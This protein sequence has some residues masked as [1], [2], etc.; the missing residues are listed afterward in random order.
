MD[1]HAAT[2]LRRGHEDWMT[3]A[4]LLIDTCLVKYFIVH[5]R[6]ITCRVTREKML[7]DV[8]TAVW[9]CRGQTSLLWKEKWPRPR[10]SRKH[11]RV[12]FHLLEN[13]T[14]L[15]RANKCLKRITKFCLQKKKYNYTKDDS[16]ML[17]TQRDSVSNYYRDRFF[18]GNWKF[19]YLEH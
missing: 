19:K 8:R 6:K 15:S 2:R 12:S 14:A 9:R 1:E 7:C 18:I 13:E 11:G 5:G 4:N 10:A 16:F 17:I 3:A